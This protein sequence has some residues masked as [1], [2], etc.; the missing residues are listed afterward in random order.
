M[1]SPEE[2][3]VGKAHSLYL[4]RGGLG[5]KGGRV[6]QAIDSFWDT[7]PIRYIRFSP[8]ML[9]ACHGAPTNTLTL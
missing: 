2:E 9:H 8:T 1:R 7:C 6:S 3:I 4:L 5:I